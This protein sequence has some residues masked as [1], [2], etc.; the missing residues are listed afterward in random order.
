MFS[1]LQFV[2]PEIF[3][4][5]LAVGVGFLVAQG[6]KGLLAVFGLD[7]SGYAAAFT[8]VLVGALVVFIQGFVGLFPPESQEMI[9]VILNAVG[10]ILGMFGVHKTYKGLAS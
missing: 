2:L 7:L 4:S 10:T 6:I 8:A 1:L 9:V 3:V 5:L